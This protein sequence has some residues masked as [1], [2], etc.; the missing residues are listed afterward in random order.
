MDGHEL[1]ECRKSLGLSLRELAALWEMGTTGHDSI[2]DWEEGKK[3]VPGPVGVLIRKMVEQ[4]KPEYV[5]KGCGKS[6]KPLQ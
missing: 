3:P 6:M 4:S 5:G 1:K 2:R